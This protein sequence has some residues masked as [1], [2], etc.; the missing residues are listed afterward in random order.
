[1][2]ERDLN[3]LLHIKMHCEDISLAISAYGNSFEIF[4]S[5]VLYRNT[6]SMSMLQI[7]ELAHHLSAEF[8][9]ETTYQIPWQNIVDMRNRFAHGYLQMDKKIIWNTAI[10]NIPALHNF[11][12]CIINNSIHPINDQNEPDPPRFKP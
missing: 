9:K 12:I 4:S 8:T 10:I 5:N 2:K 1:M 11:C 7:G 6:V 3:L